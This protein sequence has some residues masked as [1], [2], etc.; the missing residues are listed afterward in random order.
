MANPSPKKELLY[1]PQTSKGIVYGVISLVCLFIG[2]GLG[3][4]YAWY[5]EP[6]V[7]QNTYPEQL[8]QSDK[9]DY[10]VAIALDYA[11]LGDIERTIYLLAQVAPDQNPLQTAADVAC[12]LSLSGSIRT[13]SDIEAMR[14]LMLIFDQ[15]REINVKCDLSVFREISPMPTVI[16][17]IPS[18]PPTITPTL[19]ITKTNVPIVVQ[20]PTLSQSTPVPSSNTSTD[21]YRVYFQYQLSCDPLNSGILQVVVQDQAGIQQIAGVPIIV[22][23]N[24]TSGQQFQR[25]FTGLKPEKGE[26]YADFAME[27]GRNY[28]VRLDGLSGPSDQIQTQV[29]DEEDGTLFSY[30]IIFRER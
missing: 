7:E 15:R 20:T 19:A 26:G 18:P 22:S 28:T 17:F 13:R 2:L 29:C 8:R 30:Q 27:A 5:I 14:A 16:S 12:D 4:V 21:A 11:A 24:T 9:N 3:L 23:W 25:F 1:E 10:V 6:V